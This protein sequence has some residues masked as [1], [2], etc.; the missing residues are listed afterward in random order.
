MQSVQEKYKNLQEYLK[1]T[2]QCCSRFFQWRGFDISARSGKGN[3]WCGS[4]DRSYGILL[5]FPEKGVR[6]GKAVLQGAGNQTHCMQVG[7][8]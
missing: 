4:C 3:T 5:F 2:G 8:T 1:V 6:G 7:R